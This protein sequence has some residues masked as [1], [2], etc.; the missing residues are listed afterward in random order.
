MHRLDIS[1]ARVSDVARLQSVTVVETLLVA[2][3]GLVPWRVNYKYGPVAIGL[4]QGQYPVPVPRTHG[5]HRV[6]TD[7]GPL[8]LAQTQKAG[9]ARKGVAEYRLRCSQCSQ[10]GKVSSIDL[11]TEDV[12]G[13]VLRCS[14][15]FSGQR[16]E[17]ESS[18]ALSRHHLPGSWV[19]CYC[20]PA[21]AIVRQRKIESQSA[22][23]DFPSSLSSP[24]L[25][26]SFATES[27]SS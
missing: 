3:L 6:R 1:G 24:C 25:A 11:S 9:Y 22:S 4:N 7:K 10:V 13:D 2:S 16:T 5:A 27:G 15:M 14:Q 19:I 20:S 21:A 17:C 12:R 26:D 8:F 18:M 23:F